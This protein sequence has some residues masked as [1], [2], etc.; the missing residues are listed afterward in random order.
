MYEDLSRATPWKAGT[1]PR[2]ISTKES[3]C[4]NGVKASFSN[5]E[6]CD[7]SLSEETAAVTF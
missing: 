3:L 6:S 5:H 2:G 1:A 7:F 4:F